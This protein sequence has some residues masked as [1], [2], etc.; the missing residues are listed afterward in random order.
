M[1]TTDKHEASRDLSVTAE[2]LVLSLSAILTELAARSH[3]TIIFFILLDKRPNSSEYPIYRCI[4]VL[5][6]AALS[7]F[8][9]VVSELLYGITLTD[10]M[11]LSL[12]T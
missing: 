5:I 8:P 9:R 2:L 3:Y 4:A 6:I 1:L 7:M 12:T 10:I 11:Y